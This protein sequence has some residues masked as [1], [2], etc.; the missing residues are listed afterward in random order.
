MSLDS[1]LKALDS[2]MFYLDI[3]VCEDLGMRNKD[4]QSMGTWVSGLSSCGT[5]AQM[6][7]T[8]G[9]IHVPCFGKWILNHWAHR[10]VEVGAFERTFFLNHAKKVADVD[11]AGVAPGVSGK[12]EGGRPIRDE[13]AMPLEGPYYGLRCL[14]TGHTPFSYRQLFH[15]GSERR[16]TLTQMRVYVMN[17]KQGDADEY[18]LD[19]RLLQNIEYS[20]LC[21]TS[22]SLADVS[23]VTCR[24]AVAL[25]MGAV[26]CFANL[27][28]LDLLGNQWTLASSILGLNFVGLQ[29]TE[30][31]LAEL[32]IHMGYFL[33][34]VQDPQVLREQR[35]YL[36]LSKILQNERRGQCDDRKFPTYEAPNLELSKTQ[37]A[38]VRQ[39]LYRTTVLLQKLPV[40]NFPKMDAETITQKQGIEFYFK[41]GSL[42]PQKALKITGVEEKRKLQSQLE[43]LPTL[44]SVLKKCKGDE[45][46]KLV[47][48]K[49][50]CGPSET[51]IRGHLTTGFPFAYREVNCKQHSTSELGTDGEI[52][53]SQ[54]YAAQLSLSQLHSFGKCLLSPY[55]QPGAVLSAG[56]TES[57]KLKLTPV[58][59]LVLSPSDLGW[60]LH[61][62]PSWVSF[63]NCRSWD[64]S[65]SILTT[66]SKINEQTHPFL[67]FN[68]TNYLIAESQLCDCF[69]PG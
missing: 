64:F 21:Y 58:A 18:S 65:D 25:W 31:V 14:D 51:Q 46:G 47:D 37:Q 11:H 66:E 44:P 68:G 52:T 16:K 54:G 22:M 20:S 9:R 1:L 17:R 30:A 7:H 42:A 15:K 55:F 43:K 39:L 56:D 4:S 19:V 8:R 27:V 12:A 67:S 23:A 3:Q 35:T 34:K 69:H 2:L 50:D 48:V 36:D 49:L 57:S 38:P 28:T 6:P 40:L 63:A 10:K 60:N 33:E 32:Q 5:G 59:F 41:E 13:T 26:H 62:Q 53:D 45:L 61:H 29:A 24:Y